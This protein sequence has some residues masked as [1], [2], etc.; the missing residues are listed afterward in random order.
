MSKD[1][2]SIDRRFE[3]DTHLKMEIK[4]L[5]KMAKD[6]HVEVQLYI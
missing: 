2:W 6:Q 5:N 4:R 3:D 1:S